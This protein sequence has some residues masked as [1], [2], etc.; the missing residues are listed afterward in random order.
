M[1][2]SQNQ[3]QR[4][5]DDAR[6]F[7]YALGTLTGRSREIFVRQLQ[8]DTALQA[9]VS[10]WEEQLMALQD[11]H[12]SH[13]PHPNTWDAIVRRINAVS[14]S[15]RPSRWWVFWRWA[16]PGSL[17]ALLLVALITYWP[18]PEPSSLPN[19]DYVAVLTDDSGEAL[20]TAL[21]TGRGETMWLKWED[22]VLEE[23]SSAQLWAVS[24]RD[25]GVRPIAV[26]DSPGAPSLPLSDAL[27]RLIQDAE[28][29]LLT[30][31][32]PGG[33]ALDQPSSQLL[34]RGVCVRFVDGDSST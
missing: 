25:G 13:P 10:F 32:E 2:G 24:R 4:L 6:C 5:A 34:A 3:Q 7:E 30:E 22:L 21:T 27:W 11:P 20:L 19:A 1:P 26:F 33:S 16:F 12:K 14:H 23:D 8:F 17:A 31:E 28:Y 18:L 9:D 29:L 15:R